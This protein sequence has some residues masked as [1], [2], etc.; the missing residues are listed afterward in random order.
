M[1][2][3]EKP[4]LKLKTKQGKAL[5]ANVNRNSEKRCFGCAVWSSQSEIRSKWILPDVCLAC[6]AEKRN[7]LMSKIN[8][9]L[10]VETIIK[11]S[12]KTT[13][14]EKNKTL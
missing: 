7:Y 4:A 5:D 6:E 8:I 12:V 9:L 1:S 2:L 13:R 3:P 11:N 14:K 10:P